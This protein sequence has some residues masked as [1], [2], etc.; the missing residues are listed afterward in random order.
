MTTRDLVQAMSSATESPVLDIELQSTASQ[1]ETSRCKICRSS[2]LVVH[3]HTAKCKECGALLF[4]PY[5]EVDSDK[6]NQEWDTWCRERVL[7][8]YSES[9]FYNH[10]NFTN[11]VLFAM[12]ESYKGR[13]LNILD[14]GAGGGQ[15][16]L[17]CK[18]LFPQ[19]VVYT[20]DLSDESLLDEWKPL[21]N[22][23]AFR[24]FGTDPTTFDVIFLNDVLE[25]LSKPIDALRQLKGK[26]TRNGV[27][28]VDTPKQFWLYPFTRYL[29]KTMYTKLLWA[30]VHESHLQLW[31]KPSFMQA[32]ERSGLRVKKYL[33]TSEFTMPPEYYLNN[34]GLNHPAVRFL[35]RLFYRFARQL[36]N[37]KILAVLEPSE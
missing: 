17:V 1:S 6:G 35:G 34:M 14:Y 8:W 24:S 11:M 15:F 27:I 32:L 9:S 20:T 29:S 21:N 12:G 10:K 5:P 28:F 7:P 23:I 31:T 16:A 22:Q 30:T 37:N 18:S 13:N 19:A 33:E 36:A 2:E 4:W 26:L 25:H 3:A